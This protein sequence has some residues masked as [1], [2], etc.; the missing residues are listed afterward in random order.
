MRR[1]HS[2]I[3]LSAVAC[4]VAAA[5]VDKVKVQSGQLKGATDG[6]VV[7]FKGIPFAASPTGSNRWRAPQP[8][9]AWKGVRSA[10]NYGS[11]CMQLP[12]P[13]D[14]APLGNSPPRIACI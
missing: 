1:I 14:A 4:G 9:A 7:S 6:A 8:V 13:G 12:F 10:A 5:A 2:I 3:L 11:D